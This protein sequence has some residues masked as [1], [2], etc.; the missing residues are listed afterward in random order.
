MTDLTAE[1]RLALDIG[2]ALKKSNRIKRARDEDPF[3]TIARHISEQLRLAGWRF[4][5]ANTGAGNSLIGDLSRRP[6]G[7]ARCAQDD[8]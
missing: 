5:H 6:G 8:P 1:E 3:P 4:E 2:F 7:R